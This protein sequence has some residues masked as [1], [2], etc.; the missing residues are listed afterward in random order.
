MCEFTEYYYYLELKNKPPIIPN[1]TQGFLCVEDSK[2]ELYEFDYPN[3]R[4]FF[5]HRINNAEIILRDLI[6]RFWKDMTF[7]EI[8]LKYDIILF[9]HS[10]TKIGVL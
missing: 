5:F 10:I 7:N 9:E 2:I 1:G 6:R 3:K 8:K 4:I